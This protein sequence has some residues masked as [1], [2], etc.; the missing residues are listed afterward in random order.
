MSNITP[1]T[2]MDRTGHPTFIFVVDGEVAEIQ[3]FPPGDQNDARIAALSSDPKV[4]VFP[5]GFT[6]NGS[7]P[8]I[9]S[10]YPSP[11]TE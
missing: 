5:G 8:R 1:M 9:G 7:L 4:Y 3:S 2:P 6:Q 10:P 11:T